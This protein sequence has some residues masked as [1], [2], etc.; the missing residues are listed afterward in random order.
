[1]GD[2]ETASGDVFGYVLAVRIG[3]ATGLVIA[4]DIVGE[5]ASEERAVLGETPNLAARLQASAE[6]GVVVIAN[7][8]Q[9]LIDGVFDCTDRGMN[10]YK[11]FSKPLRSWAVHAERPSESRFEARRGH[12]LSALVGRDSELSLLLDRWEQVRDGDGQVVVLCGEA[13]IGKSR[14]T[15][16]LREQVAAQAQRVLRYQ[17]SPYHAQSA[18]YPIITALERQLSFSTEDNHKDKARKLEAMLHL[19]PSHASSALPLFAALLSIPLGKEHEAADLGE[20]RQGQNLI[21]ALVAHTLHIAQQGPLLAIFEDAHWMDPSTLECVTALSGAIEDAPALLLI[22]SRPEREAS[23]S[24]GDHVSMHTL[25]RLGRRHRLAMIDALT[26]GKQLPQSVLEAVMARTDGIPLYV[27]EL[28]RALLQG[29]YLRELDDRYELLSDLA[30]LGIPA[31]LHDSLSARL[32]RLG[33][34]KEVA[35][36]CAVIDRESRHDLI[37]AASNLEQQALDTALERL[38]EA[39]LLTRRERADGCVFS[40]KHALVRDAAYASL[41]RG[42][43]RGLHQLIADALRSHFGDIAVNEPELLAYHYTQA[44]QNELAVRYWKQ[45]GLRARKRSAS[46][47]TVDHLTH[48]LDLLATLPSS[49]NRDKEELEIQMALGPA[50][51]DMESF[52]SP[53]VERIYLRATELAQRTN[54]IAEACLATRGLQIFNLMGSKI[55]R[56]REYAERLMQLANND[57]EQTYLVGAHHALGQTLFLVGE[58]ESC[59]SVLE[60]GIAALGPVPRQVDN[61][62]GGQPGEQC[63]IYLALT[64]WALGYPEQGR[65][66]IEQAL[67]YSEKAGNPFSLINTLAMAA[68]FHGLDRNA[69]AMREY[70]ERGYAMAAEYRRGV[71]LHVCQILRGIAQVLDGLK[72]QGRARYGQVVAVCTPSACAHGTRSGSPHC[73]VRPSILTQAPKT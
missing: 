56:S 14:L 34:A 39:E 68:M 59:R 23:L 72:G 64:L 21:D 16:A 66:Q 50:V 27:E 60:A 38:V 51:L 5:G 24:V 45:A 46:S 1:V 52:A 26:G 70:A 67:A 22:T 62:P 7:E 43:R 61:W 44:G 10:T 36:L 63:Q 47:E 30:D 11:G 25:S 18:F 48:S 35:Q 37:L 15:Q 28:I 8:T 57:P 12:Q 33:E 58:L 53:S 32:D 2:L 40:F 20:Q 42:P 4:G 71:F 54:A 49:A 65:A 73:W 13:G 41:L 69:A 9:G 19:G 31:T 29:E 6:P 17:C 55:S 3:I